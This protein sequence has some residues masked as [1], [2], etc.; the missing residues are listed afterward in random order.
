ML[1]AWCA[2]LARILH[3][4]QS[5]T[6]FNCAKHVCKIWC[7]FSGV[8]GKKLFLKTHWRCRLEIFAV[9]ACYLNKQVFVQQA[10][11]SVTMCGASSR[12]VFLYRT[13]I[14]TNIIPFLFLVDKK[15][16]VFVNFAAIQQELARH[17][18]YLW[19]F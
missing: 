15:F 14:A 5:K 6:P 17:L 16:L 4:K 3:N 2:P 7:V 12:G 18:G 9:D 1:F 8:A 11:Q 13:C 10:S 19:R